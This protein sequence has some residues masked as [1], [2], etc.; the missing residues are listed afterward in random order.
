MK[1]IDQI[2]KI[3]VQHHGGLQDASNQQIMTVWNSLSD[4]AKKRYMDTEKGKG[5]TDA[6][7]N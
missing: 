2:R 7:G 1:E 3:V 5:K 4:D 6:V